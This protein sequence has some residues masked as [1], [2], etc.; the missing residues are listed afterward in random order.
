ML[1]ETDTDLQ[2]AAG[3]AVDA[4][5]LLLDGGSLDATYPGTV[6]MLAGIGQLSEEGCD[7]DAIEITDPTVGLL[8]ATII[9]TLEAVSER[10]IPF[11]GGRDVRHT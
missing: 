7:A 11:A 2:V 1:R 8:V 10:L 3:R 9:G 4:A 5:M 6:T